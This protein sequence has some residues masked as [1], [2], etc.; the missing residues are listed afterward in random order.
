[1]FFFGAA[2]SLS[3]QPFEFSPPDTELLEERAENTYS[4]KFVTT[5]YRYRSDSAKPVVVDFYRRFLTERDFSE[6]QMYPKREDS[7]RIAFFFTKPNTMAILSFISRADAVP[8][9]YYITII[10]RTD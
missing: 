9:N 5:K 8:S 6:T 10:T 2:I 3:A 4:D 1:M 7:Q